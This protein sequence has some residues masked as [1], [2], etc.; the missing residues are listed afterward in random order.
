VD[1]FVM[2]TS[3]NE[4]L[5]NGVMD[6]LPPLSQQNSLRLPARYQPATQALGEQAYQADIYMTLSH[7]TKLN[8]NFSEALTLG[9]SLTWREIFAELEHKINTKNIFTL[10]FQSVLYDYALYRSEPGYP[11]VMSQTPFISYIHKFTRKQS[12][13]CELQYQN[14]KQDYGSWAYA[15]AEYDIAP[16]WSFSASDMYLLD[17]NTEIT[18]KKIHFYNFFIGYTEHAT[19]YTLSWARQTQGINCSGGVCRLEP[20]F[21]GVKVALTTTF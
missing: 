10:G 19:R 13:H 16:H 11:N 7:K 2:R 9:N 21:S 20:A 1:H 4:T 12:L 18:D 8:V 17:P 14:T 5:L 3:P 6:F 15:S